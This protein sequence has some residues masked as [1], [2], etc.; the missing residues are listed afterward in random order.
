MRKTFD[1]A[2]LLALITATVYCWSTARYNGFLHAANLDTDMMERNFH[3]VMY[4]GLVVSFKYLLAFL[5]VV[6][7][8]WLLYAHLILPIYVD[9]LRSSIKARRLVVKFR[10]FWVGKRK[11][12]VLEK[13]EK[14]RL[15]NYLVV[16]FGGFIFVASLA[17]FERQ[18]VQSAESLLSRY[19]NDKS[20]EFDLISTTIE[21]EK[22]KL[23]F[24]GCGV[25]NCA[26]LTPETNRIYYFDQSN[27]YSFAYE[28]K[29]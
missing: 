20:H 5:I 7:L 10:K 3:Q 2:L 16:L 14:N 1:S 23:L 19:E 22:R 29:D 12:T 6:T 25:R 9:C 26:G 11:D 15:N 18:G 27:G 4:S 8:I 28:Y 24:L 17:F 13:R 21:G